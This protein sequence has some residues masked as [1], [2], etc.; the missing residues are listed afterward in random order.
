MPAITEALDFVRNHDWPTIL[1]LIRSHEVPGLIQFAIYAVCGG[2]ATFVYMATSL[3]LSHTIIPAMDGML[4]DGAEMTHSHR[5]RNALINN[6]IAFALANAVGYVTNVMFVFK[7]GR[8]SPLNEFLLFTA[9][10]CVAFVI[11]QFAGPYLIK[12]YGMRTIYALLLNVLASMM[13]NFVIRKFIVFK[14]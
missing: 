9:G 2:L 1:K 13:L 12:R 7:S 3:I 8:H 5:A 6:C 10:N 4:V 14:G 11:S